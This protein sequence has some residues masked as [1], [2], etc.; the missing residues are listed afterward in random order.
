MHEVIISWRRGISNKGKVIK[1]GP[2]G[3]KKRMS[4]SAAMCIVECVIPCTQFWFT[5]TLFISVISV[6]WTEK[7]RKLLTTAIFGA[8]ACCCGVITNTTLFLLKYKTKRYLLP[9]LLVE[10]LISVSNKARMAENTSFISALMLI[11][12]NYMRK[13]KTAMKKISE[14]K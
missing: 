10:L 4:R 12:E 14:G 2:P 5:Q 9:L 3:T 13:I 8:E 6:D 11:L 1:S 7:G